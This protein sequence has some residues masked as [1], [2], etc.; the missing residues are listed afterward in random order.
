ME[1][2]VLGVN[3]SYVHYSFPSMTCMLY[4]AVRRAIVTSWTILSQPVLNIL[5]FPISGIVMIIY[6]HVNVHRERPFDLQPLAVVAIST[7]LHVSES[8][9]CNCR[10]RHH[11][12]IFRGR[13]TNL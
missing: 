5:K 4:G 11:L 10:A 3:G 12:L 7:E 8:F 1:L 13:V 6:M 9:F 2:G